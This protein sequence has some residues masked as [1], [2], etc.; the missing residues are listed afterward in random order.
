MKSPKGFSKC[1]VCGNPVWNKDG[2]KHLDQHVKDG[3]IEKLINRKN[4]RVI[5]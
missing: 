3:T 1:L 2:Q 5:H 4:V